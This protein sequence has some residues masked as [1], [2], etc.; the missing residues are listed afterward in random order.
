MTTILNY[1]RGMGSIF[2]LFPGES[3]EVTV[4]PYCDRWSDGESLRKDWENICRDFLRA[5]D[6]VEIPTTKNGRT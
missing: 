4:K 3:E 1:L 6:D 5:W 2:D